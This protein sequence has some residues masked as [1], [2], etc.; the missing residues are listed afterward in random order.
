MATSKNVTIKF[1]ADGDERLLKAFKGLAKGQ[2]K[3][4]QQN[5]KGVNGLKRYNRNQM[6]VTKGNSLLGGSFAVLR[7][8]MLLFSFAMSLGIRQLIGFGNQ[9]AKVQSMSRAFK[10]LSGATGNSQVAL[11]KL[12]SATNGAMS[13]FDLFKQ[14]NNAM[15]LGVTKNSSEM[16]E[17][18]DIAQRLGRALGRDTASSVESLVTGIGRQSRMMLDNIGIIVKSDEAYKEYAKELRKSVDDLTDAERKQAFL[19]ATMDAARLKVAF[20]GAEQLTAVDAFNKL[21]ASLSDL[22]LDIGEML[23]PVMVTA[24]NAISNMKSFLD[25]LGETGIEKTIRQLVEFGGAAEDIKK[26]EEIQLSLD[27]RDLNRQLDEMGTKFSSSKEVLS[28]IKDLEAE[29]LTLL[30]S[31]ISPIDKSFSG[32]TKLLE[33]K[34]KSIAEDKKLTNMHTQRDKFNEEDIQAQIAKVNEAGNLYYAE[35]RIFDAQKESNDAGMGASQDR[36]DLNNDELDGLDS[37]L[38]ILLKIEAS[39]M[40]IKGGQTKPDPVEITAYEELSTAADKSKKSIIANAIETGKAYKNSGLAAQ[41]A[42]ATVILAEAQKATAIL[43]SK[44]L[45]QVP[46]PFN[47]I[48]GA[49]AGATVGSLMQ[50]AVGEA[51]K[52]KFEDGG[53]VGGRRHSAGGTLIEAEQG[54]FVMSRNAVNAVGIEAMNRINSGGGAGSVVV[55]VSG[56]VMSQDYVEGELA[57]QLK[58]AIRRGADIG[59]A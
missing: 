59:V 27:I 25:S 40:R 29:N 23:I 50:G 51:K 39:R 30:K 9:A 54:E 8:K 52:L 43:I 5:K 2:K 3:F 26:L 10:S 6:R 12:K 47:L 53:L 38:A 32:H 15:I 28:A 16:A 55:N 18:F 20:L 34:K 17:M 11:L 57:N 49:A 46:Y 7:S 14:A 31:Q 41:D 45:S 22:A 4:N 1:V 19:N 42:A 13:E 56:N 35:K 58:E 21:K 37:I 24:A 48:L 36:V 33:L 44:I